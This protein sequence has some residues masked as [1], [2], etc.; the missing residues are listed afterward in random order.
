MQRS[1]LRYIGLTLSLLGLCGLWNV[2]AVSADEWVSGA[3]VEALC[4]FSDPPDLADDAD[5]QVDG[6]SGALAVVRSSSRRSYAFERTERLLKSYTAGIAASRYEFVQLD[7]LGSQVSVGTYQPLDLFEGRYRLALSN[8]EL[9]FDCTH[10]AMDLVAVSHDAGLLQL[11]VELE[12]VSA[13]EPGRAFCEHAPDG[14]AVRGHVLSARLVHVGT[15]EEL[16]SMQSA[17]GRERRVRL[18]LTDTEEEMA[19]VPEVE[20][21]KIETIA[22]FDPAAYQNLAPKTG[23]RELS[24][25]HS[26]QLQNELE[27]ALLPCYQRA[28]AQAGRRQG[29]LTFRARIGT[30]GEIQQPVVTIDV[31]DSEITSGCSID[32]LNHLRFAQLRSDSGLELGFVVIFRVAE[33]P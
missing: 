26:Q 28:L 11:V 6:G 9:L 15:D 5:A 31:L 17:R 16:C 27:T 1:F 24:P 10:E 29:A 4:A 30:E 7:T 2:D 22:S 32:T 3:D 18:G 14:L 13:E 20:V 8:T 19:L 25:D 12:L 21:T 33:D 23:P